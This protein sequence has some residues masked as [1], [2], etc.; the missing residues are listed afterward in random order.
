MKKF[1]LLLQVY[2]LFSIY[3]WGTPLPPIEEIHTIKK[4]HTATD[5]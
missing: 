3:S 2:I 4:P 1:L 5:Q